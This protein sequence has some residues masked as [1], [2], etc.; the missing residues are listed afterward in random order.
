MRAADKC[1][2]KRAAAA[3]RR[4]LAHRT[5]VAAAAAA[6]A[7]TAATRAE[8]T[9]AHAQIFTRRRVLEGERAFALPQPRNRD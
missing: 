8:F 2:E 4:E 6:A 7:V 1:D 3:Y 9:F 5:F